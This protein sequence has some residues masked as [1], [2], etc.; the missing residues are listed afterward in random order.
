MTISS[1][2]SSALSGL[3]AASKAVEVISNNVANATT[4]G[5]GRRELI[6]TARALGSIG[7]G[8]QIVGVRREA[9][10][11]L[12]NDRRSAEA[13]RD[14]SGTLAKALKRIRRP[15]SWSMTPR[16]ASWR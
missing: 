16:L 2:L 10:L 1:G 6:T 11:A 4:A 13:G 7:Q 9:D 5:Y 3:T 15:A 12:Q 8:V 14:A